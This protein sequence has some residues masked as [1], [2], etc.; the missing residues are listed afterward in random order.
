[1]TLWSWYRQFLPVDPAKPENPP[2]LA[3]LV[4][5]IASERAGDRASGLAP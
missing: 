3:K 5:R 4:G 2:Q 1:M